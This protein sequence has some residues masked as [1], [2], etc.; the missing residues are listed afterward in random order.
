MIEGFSRGLALGYSLG[1]LPHASSQSNATT[2]SRSIAEKIKDLRGFLQLAKEAL[3]IKKRA[4]IHDVCC[5]NREG[6]GA[7]RIVVI[8]LSRRHRWSSNVQLYRTYAALIERS[9]KL[10][11]ICSRHEYA[12]GF[13]DVKTVREKFGQYVHVEYLHQESQGLAANGSFPRGKPYYKSVDLHRASAVW[14]CSQGHP[15]IAA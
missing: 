5:I 15:R 2:S 8:S 11:G 14:I 3:L 10:F 7:L 1:T 12:A 9:K 4:V 6:Q 13:P